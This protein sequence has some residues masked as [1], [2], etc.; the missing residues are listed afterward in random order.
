MSTTMTKYVLMIITA[1]AMARN[2]TMDSLTYL[3]P[4]LLA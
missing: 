3:T 2:A 1:S 4:F